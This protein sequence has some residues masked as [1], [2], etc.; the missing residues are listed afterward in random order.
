MKHNSKAREIYGHTQLSCPSLFIDLL[1]KIVNCEVVMEDVIFT[2]I[3]SHEKTFVM[4]SSQKPN[5]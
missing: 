2:D 3:L 1:S 5:L 4:L